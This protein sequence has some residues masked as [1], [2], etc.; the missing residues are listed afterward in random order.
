MAREGKHL[1]DINFKVMTIIKEK[2]QIIFLV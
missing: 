1:D 2:V